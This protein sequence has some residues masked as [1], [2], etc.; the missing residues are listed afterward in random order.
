MKN[1]FLAK[2]N[3]KETILEHTENL[4]KEFYRI[5]EI[6]P[7]IKYINW[8]LLKLACIYHDFGKMNAKFQNKIIHKINESNKEKLEE[9][10]DEFNDI[11]ELPHGYLSL[12]CIDSKS[13]E[14]FTKDEV[15]ILRESIFY[16]HNRE[17][18]SAERFEELKVILN[19]DLAKYIDDFKEEYKNYA[20][21]FNDYNYL[22][23]KKIDTKFTKTVKNRI[24]NKEENNIANDE[25]D[26]GKLFIIIKG[27]LNKIDFAASSHTKVEY[28]PEKL[29]EKTVKFIKGGGYEL[30][31]LQEFMKE[32]K[33]KNVIIKAS[34]GIG[35][36]EGALI[37]IG[38]NKGF[39]TLPLKV[40]INSIYDRI[41]DSSKIN[42]PKNKT[43]LLHSDSAS[44]YLK[45]D[46][47]GELDKEYLDSTKQLAY[48]LTICTIDQLIGFIF[49]YEGFEL[50]LATL[51][52]SKLVIDEIQMYAPDLV[53]YLIIA[54]RD[55]VKM[56]GQ[57][58]ILT[59]TLPPIFEYFMNLIGITEGKNY[60]KP[61]KSFIKKLD[62][63]PMLRHKIRVHDENISAKKI[64]EGYSSNKV[65]IIVNTVKQAQKLYN[66]LKDKN[67]NGNLNMFHSKFI[68]RDRA[69]KEE[70]IFKD[71]Q[72]KNKFSGIWITTQ[73]VEA[74]LDIDFD[75]LYTELSD[76][77]GL[78]QRMGRVYRNRLLKD[79]ENINI[80][81]GNSSNMP[82]GIG[83][84]YS[85]IDT[86]AF[87]KS[88]EIIRK[89]D[90]K[91]LDEEIKMS[92]VEE[93][94][95][96]ENMK[97][98]AYFKK[99]NETIYA[100]KD[101]EAYNLKKNEKRLRDIESVTIIPSKIY[102][103][104]QD[105]IIT[106]KESLKNE[107]DYS[108]RIKLKD[109]LM[110]YTLSISKKEFEGKIRKG[111][112]YDDFKIND[113]ESFIISYFDYSFE[114]GLETDKFKNGNEFTDNQFL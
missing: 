108:K 59:A 20:K 25:N 86:D 35:K 106:L 54:I 46:N 12:G 34:T 24:L 83:G 65:L 90:K 23:L 113:Y 15:K 114:K 28:E 21:Y 73:V 102:L 42:N 58:A 37:W 45:R 38:E 77:S 64:L 14:G 40:S 74:S 36:T 50:K 61:N 7:N 22:G 32:N 67:F 18:L 110:Q 111:A 13:L 101:I 26:I 82:S 19:N 78:L 62:G 9:L 112:K 98:S 71:G 49:R 44:E 87:E 105:K 94:Y 109:E 80:F 2:S 89:Y 8:D 52:Y 75:I 104:N 57:F 76:I 31:D 93:V 6:Y 16:H 43:A 3:P 10:E 39:F 27:L 81:V 29:D 70:E 56:G 107:M 72:L 69:K 17:K 97:N 63:K 11:E 91:E 84:E 5:K 68:K 99:I 4:V 60:I 53:A 92:M 100:F 95:S 33:D 1:L 30:N 66:D 48:P 55:I 41:I 103:E 88:K 51:S 96:V 79:K 47:K 85:I